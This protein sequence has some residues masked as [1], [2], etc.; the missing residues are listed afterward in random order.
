MAL[1]IEREVITAS[2]GRVTYWKPSPDGREHF[3]IKLWLEGPDD[4]L[5]EVRLVEYKLHESFHRQIRKSEKRQERFA[6]KIWTWGMFK[7]QATVHFRD[8]NTKKIPYYLS[9]ELPPDTGS[10]Y[11]LAAD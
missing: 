6:I 11:V 3:H 4:E 5:D 2:D 10:N 9:Y 8:G 7:L 1:R